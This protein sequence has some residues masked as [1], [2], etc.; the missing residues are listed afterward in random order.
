MPQRHCGNARLSDWSNLMVNYEDDTYHQERHPE[1][2]D[3][4]ELRL[5]WSCFSDLAYFQHVKPGDSVL[6]YGGGLGNNLLSV[7][8]RAKT[9]MVEPSSIGRNLARKAGITVASSLSE[10]SDQRFDTVLCRHVLEHVDH[11]LTTL[12][13][14]LQ[15][16]KDDGRL[17]LV[18]PCEKMKEFPSADDLDHHLYCWSP[19]TIAN[20]LEKAGYRVDKIYFEHFGAKRKLLPLY[21]MM[22]GQTYAHAVRLVGKLF[23]FKELVVQ[24]SNMSA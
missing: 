20:L 3:D 18:L 11:P 4:D 12:K 16:L 6:E 24:A 21:G 15:A 13:E 14:L 1:L 10:I 5:A 8:K 19:K 9:W 2:L 17:I 7:S 23:S 22:G